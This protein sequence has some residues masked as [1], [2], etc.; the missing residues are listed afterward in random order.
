MAFK[1]PQRKKS[2]VEQWNCLPAFLVSGKKSWQIISFLWRWR[3]P[4]DNWNEGIRTTGSLIVL[5]TKQTQETIIQF[6]N[7]VSRSG[8]AIIARHGSRK[9]NCVRSSMMTLLHVK[10]FTACNFMEF[11][12][13][14]KGWRKQRHTLIRNKKFHTSLKARKIILNGLKDLQTRWQQIFVLLWYDLSTEKPFLKKHSRWHLS[15]FEEQEVDNLQTLLITST[16]N[17]V[18]EKQVINWIINETRQRQ[19]GRCM[20][21]AEK[22]KVSL[23]IKIVPAKSSDR[24]QKL[25]SQTDFDPTRAD[26]WKMSMN[27]IP[28]LGEVITTNQRKKKSFCFWK[29]YLQPVI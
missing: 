11:R 28:N 12:P 27:L 24:A 10:W 8:E 2:A 5:W 13:K 23:I 9:Q 19:W 3:I 20:R 14:R 26:M 15:R 7:L 1:W 16:V 4:F 25:S 18:R 17:F 22:V 6:G 21:E 29:R